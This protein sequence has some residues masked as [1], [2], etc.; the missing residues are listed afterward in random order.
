VCALRRAIG[1]LKGTNACMPHAL[2]HVCI[3]AVYHADILS[4]THVINAKYVR[5]CDA[6]TTRTGHTREVV[7]DDKSLR[8]LT[9]SFLTFHG[10]NKSDPLYVQAEVRPTRISRACACTF[11]A[12]ATLSRT[13]GACA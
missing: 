13:A 1:G 10:F 8:K 7:E 11:I 9:I 3:L 4:I 12:R 2:I 6:T 5:V